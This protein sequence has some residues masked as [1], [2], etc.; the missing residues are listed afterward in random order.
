[1]K[2]ELK[3]VCKSFKNNEVI[4]NVSM[5]FESGKIYGLYGRNGAGKTVLLKLISGFYVPT[6]GEILYDDKNLNAELMFP[7]D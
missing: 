5:V 3:N 4:S 1:M 2:I 7:P 6:S